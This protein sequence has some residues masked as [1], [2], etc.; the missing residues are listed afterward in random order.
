MAKGKKTKILIK[1]P[2]PVQVVP[3]V[4]PLCLGDGT[5]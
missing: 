2:Q 3:E 5:S 4:N 1:T